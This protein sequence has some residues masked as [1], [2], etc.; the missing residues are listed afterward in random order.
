MATVTLELSTPP[1][2]KSRVDADSPWKLALDLYFADFM[3]CCLPDIAQEIDWSKGFEFLDK[4][5]QAIT[6]DAQ[7][8]RRITDKLIKLWRKNQQEIF[9][10]CHLEVQKYDKTLPERMLVYRYRLRDRYHKPIVS[11]A[12]LIDDKPNWRPDFYRE[13]CYGSHLEIHFLIVKLLDFRQRRE[14]LVAMDNRFATVLLAQLIVLETMNN[15]QARLKA[16]TALTRALYE[17]G[18]RKEDILQLYTLVD[19]L[20]TLPEQLSIYYNNAIK[21]IEEEQSVKNVN[22]VTTAQ[23]IGRQEGLQEGEVRM[24]TRLL[25]CRF[26]KISAEL[27]AKIQQADPA[28]LLQ[29]AE[30]VL[31]ADSLAEVFS[32]SNSDL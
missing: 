23:R 18:W 14:E 19:W 29:W 31:D 26:Q 15:P 3:D 24:L 7:I 27:R 25:E 28:T 1:K 17:K 12:I 5:L 21:Q 16:K 10:L 30:R 4:E 13:T 22:Y 11:V 8:G 6:Y 32:N 9:F 2:H 20:I